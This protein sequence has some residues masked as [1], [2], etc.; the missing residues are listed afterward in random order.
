MA[1]Y[2]APALRTLIAAWRSQPEAAAGV[3][4]DAFRWLELAH[5]GLEQLKGVTLASP[6]A[7][8]AFH[9]AEL[10]LQ[11]MDRL[12]A[13][14]DP[15]SATE[16]ETSLAR[17]YAQLFTLGEEEARRPS[18]S[19]VLELDQLIIACI[20]LLDGKLELA[21]FHARVGPA[22]GAAHML[23]LGQIWN[24]RLYADVPEPP[25]LEQ[26]LLA[27]EGGLGAV[28]H[29]L[30]GGDFALLQQAIAWLGTGSKAVGELLQ[31]R[32]EEM[33]GAA[34]FSRHPAIESWL[35]QEELDV[36]LGPGA[37]ETLWNALHGDVQ[38]LFRLLQSARSAGLSVA[39]PALLARAAQTHQKLVDALAQVG[40]AAL[41]SDEVASL[42]NPLWDE[43]R[44][45]QKTLESSVSGLQASLA[46]TPRM[47]DLLETLG[48]AE[49]GQVPPWLLR[50]E[51]EA[52]LSEQAQAQ[53]A[54]EAAPETCNDAMRELLA[55][56]RPALERMRLFCDDADPVHLQEGWKL[57]ALSLPRLVEFGQELR[58]S[59]GVKGGGGQVV[60]CVRCGEVQPPGRSCRKCQASLPHLA[61]DET[62]Y[63]N[64]S[65]NEQAPEGAADVLQT[66]VEGL[67]IGGSSWQDVADEVNRQLEGVDKIRQRFEKELLHQLGKNEM[68]D[69]YSQFFAVRVGQL[70]QTLLSIGE[71]VGTRNIMAVTAC[72]GPYR[73]LHEEL[74]AFQ[75]KINEGIG[76]R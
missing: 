68:L 12:L 72:L 32:L 76:A 30:N 38:G 34:R 45:L 17:Y 11:A 41:P 64:I 48:Q 43:L 8:E 61:L 2:F 35:R 36:D 27:I 24:A 62:R 52:H 63:E 20:N 46:P 60:T 29:V 33:K 31:K 37:R 49:A 23:R 65:G 10:E 47:R 51:L 15:L 6:P 55:S 75:G 54:M 56:H 13:A 42:L 50:S 19:P 28:E 73:Q 66:L 7:E 71:A 14:G 53:V 18:F 25:E 69:A 1:S 70:A 26:N 67:Q 74:S 58:A 39:E 5:A 22:L 9:Q 57:L 16:L 4:P 40:A 44:H 3:M 21:D 59:V